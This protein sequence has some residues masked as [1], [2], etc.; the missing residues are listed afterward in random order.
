MKLPDFLRKPATRPDPKTEQAQ[1]EAQAFLNELMALASTRGYVIIAQM[2]P[3]QQQN[4]S[5]AF[6]P[7][8]GLA[9]KPK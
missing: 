1:K 3:V 7:V 5:V 8:W 2:Q 6:Q 4:G 9:E